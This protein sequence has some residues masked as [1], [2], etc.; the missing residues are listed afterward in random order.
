MI[1][2][3]KNI[4]NINLAIK[5]TLKYSKEYSFIPLQIIDDNDKYINCIFQTPSLFIP[6]GLQQNKDNKYILDLSFHNKEN[7]K[8]LCIFEENLQRIFKIISK[9]YKQFNVNPFLK[10][11]DYDNCMRF[12][13]NKFTKFYDQFKNLTIP[14]P[15]LYGK[16]IIH[17]EGLWIY[18]DNDIWFQ[19][20]LL[21]GK[22]YQ[23]I[24]LNKYSF[25]D[26]NDNNDDKYE[27]MIKM[28]V[29]A[30]AVNIKKNIDK[31]IPPPP[32]LPNF[33]NKI[34]RKSSKIK[35]ED[36]KNVVLKKSKPIQKY[37]QNNPFD[38]PT[39]EELQNMISRLKK[40]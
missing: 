38:P 24:K 9:K 23:E 3:H 11:T 34:D 2:N 36:L 13:I 10:K 31:G 4:N 39:M 28:G 14:K 33:E 27:K 32:P 15:Y 20:S 19:W 37:K 29:P 30:E 21:Q 1:I 18:K 35:A 17:L 12:K 8:N 40:I 22:L 16:F 6:Y 26:D 5:N 25:I 7:D